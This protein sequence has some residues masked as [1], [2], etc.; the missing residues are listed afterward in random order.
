MGELKAAIRVTIVAACLG[1]LI[2]ATAF[3]HQDLWP[4]PVGLSFPDL[5]LRLHFDLWVALVALLCVGAVV[6]LPVDNDFRRRRVV[7][8][9]ARG[10]L[11]LVGT[12]LALAA[13]GRI[14]YELGAHSG[15]SVVRAASV[16]MGSLAAVVL[17][18]VAVRAFMPVLPAAATGLA[19]CVGLLWPFAR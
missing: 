3:A 14:L 5:L 15:A 16:S 12:A 19:V 13:D 7:K 8:L 11:L 10:V 4:R 18:T 2:M 17:A 6:G 1:P 9:G